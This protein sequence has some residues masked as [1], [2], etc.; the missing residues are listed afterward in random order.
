MRAAKLWPLAVVAVLVVT[1]GA[2][3]LI[4]YL[5]RDPGAAVVERDYYRRAVGWDSTMA[6]ARRN[7]ALGWRLEA[8]LGTVTPAGA[9]LTVRLTDR[10]GAPLA[11][12]VVRVEAVHNRDAAHPVAAALAPGGDGAYAATL[13]LRRLGMW[14]LR[15]EVTRGAER[16]TQSLRR[17]AA[18]RAGAP[19]P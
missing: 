14:E 8:G 4:Y 18:G 3:V 16:F 19:A 17:E 5:A 1:I 9:T 11:G 10:A 6:Q 12:A 13:P 7:A 2:N 15:F